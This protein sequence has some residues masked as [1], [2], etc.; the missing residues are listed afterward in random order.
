MWAIL[1]GTDGRRSDPRVEQMASEAARALANLALGDDGSRLSSVPPTEHKMSHGAAKAT[2]ADN[3]FAFDVGVQASPVSQFHFPA[4]PSA[5]SSALST[6]EPRSRQVIRPMNALFAHRV[7]V[8]LFNMNPLDCS[9][10]AAR[11]HL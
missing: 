3:S 8:G 1:A 7:H 9:V 6:P 5:A 2:H 10:G 11:C 4:S